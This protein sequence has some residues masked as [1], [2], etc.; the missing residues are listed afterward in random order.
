MK[1]KNNINNVQNYFS[2]SINISGFEYFL[3]HDIILIFYVENK[4]L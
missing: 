4:I 3:F 1:Q 2:P